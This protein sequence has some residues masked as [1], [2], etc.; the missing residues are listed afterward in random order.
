[1]KVVKFAAA[2]PANSGEVSNDH[3]TMLATSG[4][5]YA[6]SAAEQLIDGEVE[7]GRP[8]TVRESHAEGERES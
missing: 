2:N 4:D 3:R 7:W 5:A 6:H 1:M 8:V